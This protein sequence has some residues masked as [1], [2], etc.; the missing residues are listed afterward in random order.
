[1]KYFYSYHFSYL[2]MNGNVHLKYIYI[3]NNEYLSVYGQIV[4]FYYNAYFLYILNR[5]PTFH[6]IE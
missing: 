5:V 4:I 6:L 3:S 1:M 2:F